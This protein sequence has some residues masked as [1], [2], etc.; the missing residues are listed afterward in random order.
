MTKQV[1]LH[2]TLSKRNPESSSSDR[3]KTIPRK[4]REII[5]E[6]KLYQKR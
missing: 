5:A 4:R 2:F 3:S 1:T 6:N